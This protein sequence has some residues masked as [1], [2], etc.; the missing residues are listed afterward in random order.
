[1]TYLTDVLLLSLKSLYTLLKLKL[2]SAGRTVSAFTI[3]TMKIKVSMF[4]RYNFHYWISTIFNITCCTI[5][6]DS[7]LLESHFVTFQLIL[8][9]SVWAML[10]LNSSSNSASWYLLKNAISVETV[11]E[12]FKLIIKSFYVMKIILNNFQIFFL[13]SFHFL[14]YIFNHKI[15]YTHF[16]IRRKARGLPLKIS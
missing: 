9:V 5:D 12:P 15:Y 8:S 11:N 4:S 1:M 7:L 10:H 2:S 16:L 14:T 13:V 3:K 6:Y